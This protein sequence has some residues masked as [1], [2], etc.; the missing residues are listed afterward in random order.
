[1]RLI[2][3]LKGTAICSTGSKSKGMKMG[4]TS[5]M[6]SLFHGMGPGES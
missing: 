2:D 6:S 4:F 1:L 3:D 5:E